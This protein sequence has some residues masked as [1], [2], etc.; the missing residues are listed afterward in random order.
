[1]K[2]DVGTLRLA[3][4]LDSAH[5]TFACLGAELLALAGCGDSGPP[6][7]CK[8]ATC[9]PHTACS[10]DRSTGMQ[11]ATGRACASLGTLLEKDL[12]QTGRNRLSKG[13]VYLT[14]TQA[15]AAPQRIHQFD[16]G[17]MRGRGGIEASAGAAEQA[18]EARVS[19][20]TEAKQA[21]LGRATEENFSPLWAALSN[22]VRDMSSKCGADDGCTVYFYTDLQEISEPYLCTEI[23]GADAYGRS[24]ACPKNS[25]RQPPKK[26]ESGGATHLEWPAESML[27]PTPASGIRIVACGTNDSVDAS[28]AKMGPMVAQR[29][30]QSWKALFPGAEFEVY[31]T[32]SQL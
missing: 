22:V 20:L 11:D 21:C 29:R 5:R 13:Y 26:V 25:G 7:D 28:A 27:P 17:T 16:Y 2:R 24:T 18:E 4:R 12:A 23:L 3:R 8:S 31:G 32:C 15:M 10:V 1:M 9:T 30:D 14:G 6:K 19:V